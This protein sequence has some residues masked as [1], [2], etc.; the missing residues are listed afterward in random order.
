V[1]TPTA[2][3][4]P[5]TTL[6]RG[7]QKRTSVGPRKKRV[8]PRPHQCRRHFPRRQRLLP[9]PQHRS[10]FPSRSQDRMPRNLRCRP[11]SPPLRPVRRS[12]LRLLRRR[13]YLRSSSQARS[14]RR[15]HRNRPQRSPINSQRRPRRDL[16]ISRLAG[17]LRSRF[18]G[19]ACPSQEAQ[20]PGL[21][22]RIT[23]NIAKLAGS[24]RRG[25][26]LRIGFSRR[27]G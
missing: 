2:G 3:R 7:T 14:Q 26:S 9:R 21:A 19:M 27:G 10:I 8:Y 24:A 13:L 1:S 18:D 12:P 15:H 16:T 5:L 23:S 4:V 6:V 17:V 11:S 25:G 22:R 20:G